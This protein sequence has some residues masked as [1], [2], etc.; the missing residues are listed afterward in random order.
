M[1]KKK[2]MPYLKL[3]KNNWSIKSYG[4]SLE[5]KKQRCLIR[6]I[7]DIRWFK[8]HKQYIKIDIMRY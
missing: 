6:G 8:N 1:L 2:G 7:G 5:L 4:P 3:Q